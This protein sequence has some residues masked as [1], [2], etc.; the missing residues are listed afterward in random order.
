MTNQNITVVN[1]AAFLP[2]TTQTWSNG[3]H[4][5]RC[6]KAIQETWDVKTYCFMA[7]QPVMFF[8]KPG[9][10]VTLVITSYSIHYTK[11]YD[12]AAARACQWWPFANE[13]QRPNG[14]ESEQ[15]MQ[16]PD[17]PLAV[18]VQEAEVSG[19]AES[20]ITSYNVCYTKLL[21]IHGVH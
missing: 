3:R 1:T 15:T 17:Q 21:R 8:F 20:R 19:A 16:Q 11:L 9:Q 6:V 12:G 7:E 14:I 10:F 13:W 4:V 5:V 2:V 18:G